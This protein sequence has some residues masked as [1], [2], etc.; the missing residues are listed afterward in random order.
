MPI[1]IIIGTTKIKALNQKPQLQPPDFFGR[2]F[3]VPQELIDP[4]KTT[5]AKIANIRCTIF[6]DIM[7]RK[8]VIQGNIGPLHSFYSEYDLFKHN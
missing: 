5:I 3:W 2:C 8:Y 4:T 1:A 7:K 6:L